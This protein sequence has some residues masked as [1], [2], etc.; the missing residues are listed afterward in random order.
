MSIEDFED[1]LEKE[2]NLSGSDKVS[3]HRYH[4]GYAKLLY[5]KKIK[6]VLEIGIANGWID[7]SASSIGAWGKIFPEAEIYAIDID[8][9]KV[10]AQKDFA[11][12]Y[13]VDQ[14]S[15]ESLEV[16]VKKTHLKD[17]SFI[18]DDGSHYFNHAKL[19]F[20]IL[21]DSLAEDGVYIIE[22]I[23]KIPSGWNPWQQNKQDWENYLSGIEGIQYLIIDTKP[24]LNDDSLLIGI[25]KK[26]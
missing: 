12:T 20:E 22:D 15:K 23:V 21:F 19:T 18:L 3:G 13:V 8:P 14:S 10:E 2:L 1:I 4:F 25:W 7:N 17:I 6:S 9:D 11:K 24:S 26:G 5:G 16:F